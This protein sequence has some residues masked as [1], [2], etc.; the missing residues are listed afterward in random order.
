MG[1][2]RDRG[3][4]VVRYLRSETGDV[5][6]DMEGVRT[7]HVGRPKPLVIANDGF[8]ATLNEVREHG[9]TFIWARAANGL[10]DMVV[11]LPMQEYA[12][13]LTKDVRARPE[14]SME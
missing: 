5:S 11:L 1:S 2:A 14:R 6:I 7:I 3:R 13:L 10:D 9:A 4:K 12:A 8:E